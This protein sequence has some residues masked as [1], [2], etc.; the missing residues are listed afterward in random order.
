V[1]SLPD[2]FAGVN[3]NFVAIA[4]KF[5][6]NM[7]KLEKCAHIDVLQKVASTCGTMI[8]SSVPHDVK[9]L[10]GGCMTLVVEG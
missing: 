9:K 4:L 3:K 10:L 1:A 2:V 8:F 5:A 7:L 6:F